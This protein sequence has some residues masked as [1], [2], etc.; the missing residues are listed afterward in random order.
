MNLKKIIL[1][2][3]FVLMAGAAFAEVTV[4]EASS[5]EYLLNSGFSELM[6]E[7]VN[8]VKAMAN[9]EEYKSGRRGGYKYV[10]R[11]IRQYIDP[12]YDDGTLLQ[13]DIKMHPSFTD[14]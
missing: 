4:E 11:K 14:F 6:T 13:H 5:K 2:T 7:H 3:F 12:G 10:L 9:N 8:L 1:T